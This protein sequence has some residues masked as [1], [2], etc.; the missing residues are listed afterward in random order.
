VARRSANGAPGVDLISARAQRACRAHLINS[1]KRGLTDYTARPDDIL[2][3]CRRRRKF[4]TALVEAAVLTFCRTHTAAIF[5]IKKCQSSVR[6]HLGHSGVRA[7]KWVAAMNSSKIHFIK[8]FY[9]GIQ[10]IWVFRFNLKISYLELVWGVQKKS[11]DILKLFYDSQP[12]WNLMRAGSSCFNYFVLSAFLC[13][14]CNLSDLSALSFSDNAFQLINFWGKKQHVLVDQVVTSRW[15]HI[16]G[17]DC[18][19]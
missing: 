4:I 19:Q 11:N 8:L 3:L 16:L 9:A 2:H 18:H 1:P 10:K 7:L 17:S 14:Q 13:W 5:V 12:C 6:R 15:E